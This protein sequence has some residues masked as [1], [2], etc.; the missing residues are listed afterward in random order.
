[1]A[2]D[3]LGRLTSVKSPSSGQAESYTYDPLDRLETVTQSAISTG[4]ISKTTDFLYV[5]LTDAV[6][7]Q[8][9]SSG[10]TTVVTDHATDMSGAELYEF[11]AA[12]SVPVFIGRNDHGDTTWTANL[13][14]SVSA[15]ASYDP[16]GNLVSSTGSVPSWR[17]QGSWQDTVTGL[18]YVEARWYSPSLGE[19]LSEDPLTHDPT[20]PQ[21]R[22]PYAYASGDPI[23]GTDHSGEAT[24]DL[25]WLTDPD[26]YNPA[27]ATL[28]LNPPVQYF[29][30]NDIRWASQTMGGPVAQRLSGALRIARWAARVAS[31]H[32]LRWCSTTWGLLSHPAWMSRRGTRA[33]SISGS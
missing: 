9:V 11:N 26:P 23:D 7:L 21:S 13:T 24:A 33:F 22:D 16:F 27:G 4:Q 12:T 32:R 5:G 28:P 3:A 25:S 20:D 10:S 8:S 2:Y 15:T 30:Q 1:M 17:W 31:S 6:A 14:G 18:Y 19:F 29:S